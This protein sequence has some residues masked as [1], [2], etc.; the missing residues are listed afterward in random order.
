M[1]VQCKIKRSR[2]DWGTRRAHDAEDGG[3]IEAI[4]FGER[5][6]PIRREI[7]HPRQEFVASGEASRGVLRNSA[8]AARGPGGG[9]AAEEDG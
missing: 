4:F 3:A 6:L 2:K 8:R 1:P 9:G 5:T 7:P